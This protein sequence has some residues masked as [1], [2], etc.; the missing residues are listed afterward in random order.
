MNF[1]KSSFSRMKDPESRLKRGRQRIRRQVRLNAGMRYGTEREM[2]T[3]LGVGLRLL[4][5]ESYG[6]RKR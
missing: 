2:N 1:E 3:E 4:A 6:I 5:E